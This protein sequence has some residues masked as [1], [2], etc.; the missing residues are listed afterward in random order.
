M[1][2][3]REKMEA[4]FNLSMEMNQVKD[5][6]ILMEHILTWARS[7]ASADAGSIYLREGNKLKFSYTQNNT[8]QKR[9]QPGEKL[10]YSTFEIPMS[11]GMQ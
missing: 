10:I 5:I 2:T 7:F 1:L 9:L 4:L 6:D 11:M 3:E 8:L